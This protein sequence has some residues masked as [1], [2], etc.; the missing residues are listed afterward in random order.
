MAIQIGTISLEGPVILAPMSGVTDLP[1]RRLVKQSGCGLVV[2]EMVASQAMIREN[3][4]TLR[5]VECEPEQFPMAVQLAGCEP[6]VMAEAAK[7]NEDR[8]AAIID[9]NFGCPVKKVV[10]GHAGSSLMRDE[11][12]AARI[13]EATAKAVT[14]PVTLKM[15]KGWDDSSLNAPRLARIAEECG[16]KLVTVHGRTREQFY[17]GTAD[18]SFIRSVKE[19]VSIPV[20]VNG[21]ITSFDAVDR[22]LAES[23]A[24]GVMIGRGAYGRPWFPAQVMHYIRTGERLPDP[25]LHEQLDTLLEHYDAM[26]THYGVEGGLRV[27]RKHISWYSTGLRDSAEFRSEVNRMSDPERV[28]GFIRD[29]YAPAIERMAA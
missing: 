26:L 4:Q 13:L 28:R 19:A 8:G 27:A 17:N 2:S 3:R 5:M 6:D 21:D 23:G 15:R 16:I 9:I 14:I 22:A 11:A 10:N 24:D 7:L 25:P 12:L 29:F 20:V 18:W 1:F